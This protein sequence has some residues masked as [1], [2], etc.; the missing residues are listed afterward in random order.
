[1][2]NVKCG[3][4]RSQFISLVIQA[5]LVIYLWVCIFN[6][7]FDVFPYAS[8][9]Y[10][11]NVLVSWCLLLVCCK[12]IHLLFHPSLVTCYIQLWDMQ[13]GNNQSNFDLPL[14]LR[15][16]F[17]PLQKNSKFV[18]ALLSNKAQSKPRHCKLLYYDSLKSH[19]LINEL[20]METFLSSME[21]LQIG[22]WCARSS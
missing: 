7:G 22:Q 15:C 6:T 12:Y 8:F 20:Q 4:E 10:I 5:P 3:E 17:K 21:M 13:K 2:F 1:M 19:F 18:S 11:N 9:Y 16:A 14:K